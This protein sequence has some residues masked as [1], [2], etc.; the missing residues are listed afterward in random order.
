MLFRTLDNMQFEHERPAGMLDKPD[1]EVSPDFL[2]QQMATD[3]LQ[4]TE[5]IP[6][7]EEAAQKEIRDAVREVMA[8]TEGGPPFDSEIGLEENELSTGGVIPVCNRPFES[9]TGWTDL[10]DLDP[11]DP[12]AA[13]EEIRA[14]VRQIVA[15]T[16]IGVPP[17]WR[18]EELKPPPML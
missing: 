14:A 17:D 12:D 7:H 5:E 9:G 11:V 13:L 6:G 1:L 10:T 2:A 15:D 3:A 18:L 4:G 8:G 16:D